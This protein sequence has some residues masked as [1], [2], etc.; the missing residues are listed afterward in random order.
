MRRGWW[1][2]RSAHS[3]QNSLR[4][5]GRRRRVT[6]R[7]T[8]TIH[9]DNSQLSWKKIG[10]SSQVEQG[11]VTKLRKLPRPGIFYPLDFSGLRMKVAAA[12]AGGRCSHVRAERLRGGWICNLQFAV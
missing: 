3:V 6:R 8:T 2:H 5:A 4:R 10:R 7:I 9:E 1:W 12:A 11:T